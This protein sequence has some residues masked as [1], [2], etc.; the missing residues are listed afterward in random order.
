MRHRRLG[1]TGLEVSELSLGT[2]G[3]SGDGYGPVP[4]DEQDRVIERARAVGL[5]LFE[6]ADS[7]GHGAMEARL[8]R[9]LGDDAQLHIVTKIGTDREARVPRKR[10]DPEYLKASLDR[11][12][13]RS[14][15][16]SLL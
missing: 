4:D 3:L 7:Y 14:Q 1:K 9:L 15:R 8:G 16:D 6:T 5:T 11:S 10:F 13:Q 2:W 12:Q